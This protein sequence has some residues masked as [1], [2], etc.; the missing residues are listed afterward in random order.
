VRESRFRSP[1]FYF[2]QVAWLAAAILAGWLG[3]VL[4]P[5]FFQATTDAV[6]SVGRNLGLGVGVLAGVPVVIV[7]AAIT[8]VGIPVSLMH[9][10]IYSE[11]ET[12]MTRLSLPEDTRTTPSLAE[13]TARPSVKNQINSVPSSTKSKRISLKDFNDEE[14]RF[15]TT[16]PLN[17]TL[18]FCPLS[19]HLLNNSNASREELMFATLVDDFT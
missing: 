19:L 16:E 7:M 18:S 12:E 4:F 8:L 3:L 6:G 17:L 13:K 5:G 10:M 1:K 14:F 2:H 9:S 15:T 11:G